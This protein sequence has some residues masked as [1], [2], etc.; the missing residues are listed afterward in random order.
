MVPVQLAPLWLPRTCTV[1]SKSSLR[2]ARLT[3]WLPRVPVVPRRALASLKVGV[4]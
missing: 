4:L 1:A 3:V 2:A